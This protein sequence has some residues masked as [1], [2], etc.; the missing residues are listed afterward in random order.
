MIKPMERDV[1]YPDGTVFRLGK[2]IRYDGMPNCFGKSAF[3][4]GTS[5]FRF[6]KKVCQ[7][8]T[9]ACRF[10]SDILYINTVPQLGHKIF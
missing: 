1:F 4:C 6:Q 2:N 5:V 7:D 10:S 8:L 9:V 3:D